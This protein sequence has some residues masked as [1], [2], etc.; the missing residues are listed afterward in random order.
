MAI[1]HLVIDFLTAG[2]A[3][4]ALVLG[5]INRNKII[6]VHLSINSRMDELLNKTAS[7]SRAEGVEAGR[8]EQRDAD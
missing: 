7:S 1:F 8:N 4:G 2:G 3:F 5:F 6:D